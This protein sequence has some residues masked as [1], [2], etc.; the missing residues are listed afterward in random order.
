ML[1][2]RRSC[3]AR[4][5]CIGR[6]RE[7]GW[8]LVRRYD[9]VTAR[10]RSLI[11]ALMEHGHVTREC[12]EAKIPLAAAYRWMKRPEF[13]MALRTARR[14]L[15]DQATTVLQVSMTVCALKLRR[16]ALDESLPPSIQCRCWLSRRPAC[17]Y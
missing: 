4:T 10:Q 6:T 17:D 9:R 1:D 16:M 7:P 11:S 8:I 13:V 15:T 5:P 2:H 3:S 14:V 12:G